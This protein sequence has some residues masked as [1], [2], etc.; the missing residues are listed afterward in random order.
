MGPWLRSPS[1]PTSSST[2]C[3]A[4]LRWCRAATVFNFRAA[5]EVADAL[6]KR[7][8]LDEA[9]RTS[10]AATAVPPV[11]RSLIARRAALMAAW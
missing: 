2:T 9:V 4:L 3:G 10:L 7:L 8:D 5:C 11:W 1:T 6:A